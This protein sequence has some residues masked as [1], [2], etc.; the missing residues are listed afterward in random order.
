[1]SKNDVMEVENILCIN[2]AIKSLSCVATKEETQVKVNMILRE[3]NKLME[4]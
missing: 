4:H 3:L 1:M 2:D